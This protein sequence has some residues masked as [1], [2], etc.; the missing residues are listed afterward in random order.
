MKA[1]LLGANGQLGQEVLKLVP[2]SIL[3]KEVKLIP[4]TKN[5][6]DLEDAIRCKKFIKEE[7]PDWLINCAAYT[8]VDEAEIN[9]NKA[10]KINAVGPEIISRE[11]SKTDGRL[12]H[13]ST[14]FIF[15]GKQSFP[16]KTNQ[17][18]DPIN[19]YGKSKAK[20]E[21]AVLKNLDQNNGFVIRTS[22]LIS[23]VGQNFVLTMLKLLN[24]RKEINVISDQ[25]GC[26]TSTNTLA[27]AIWNLVDLK[28][29]NK[30]I[31]RIF[32]ISDSGAASWYDVAREIYEIGSNYGLINNIV[33]INPIKSIDFKC[34]ATRPSYSLLDCQDSKK[35]L[36]I[37]NIYWKES[38][39]NILFKI[40]ECNS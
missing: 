35:L 9:K 3:G 20:G 33:K 29:Q 27:K 13:I 8:K 16:Y 2:N 18:S 31:P 11:L 19:E 24:I 30:T 4:V 7:E 38:L 39:K 17:K 25:V 10:N 40:K 36:K 26:I 15:S 5:K 23:P 1:L 21:V 22:W 34:N 28:E 14:D 32:H 12:I 6:L 37:E